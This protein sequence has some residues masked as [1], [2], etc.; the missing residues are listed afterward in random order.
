MDVPQ[1]PVMDARRQ[2][3]L[4]NYTFTLFLSTPMDSYLAFALGSQKRLVEYWGGGFLTHSKVGDLQTEV[5]F[6]HHPISPKDSAEKRPIKAGYGG[7]ASLPETK[8]SARV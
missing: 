8:G 4:T 6:T 1:R 2:S 3:W 7:G 5:K